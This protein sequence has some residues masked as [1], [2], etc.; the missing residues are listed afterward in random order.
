MRER[1]S[2]RWRSGIHRLA[3]DVGLL[4][5]VAG[6]LVLAAALI[7]L[8]WVSEAR[9]KQV[10]IEQRRLHLQQAN[11]IAMLLRAGFRG[12]RAPRD[13]GDSGRWTQIRD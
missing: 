1:C 13:W 10:A 12:P 4:I 2:A 3:S 7:G 11:I 6:I 9:L 5:A 8:V